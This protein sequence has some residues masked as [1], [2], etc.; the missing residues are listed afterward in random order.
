MLKCFYYWDNIIHTN[1]IVRILYIDFWKAFDSVNHVILVD[2]F[3]ELGVHL[4]LISWLHSFLLVYQRQQRVKIRDE[5]SSW[6][7]MKGEVPRGSWLGP[8]C[9]IVYVNKIEAECGMRIHKYIDDITITVQI[10]T[11]EVSHLQK[12]L[13]SITGWS[14]RNNMKINERKTKEMTISFKKTKLQLDPITH[15][16]VPLECVDHFKLLGIWV[17]NNMTGKYHV[18]HIYATASPR[19]YYPKQLRRCGVALEDQPMFYK[20]VIVPIT[21]YACPAWHTSLT[22]HA[23]E[24]LE[25]RQKRAM[26]VIFPGL[27]YHDA[28]KTSKLPTLSTR[29]DLLCKAFF[30]QVSKPD[31][32]LNYLLEKRHEYPYELRHNQKN[33]IEIPHTERNKNNI[34]MDS[35]VHYH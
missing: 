6:L 29:R 24:T 31:H 18:V 12:S 9:F 35:L 10:T 13:D 5:V 7:T 30:M 21:E 3:R 16:G 33:K 23:T 28:L 19:L 34:I 15:E 14:S 2:R 25:N 1:K 11:C 22:K 27:K 8:L 26:S 17:S 20:S 4:V 32:K